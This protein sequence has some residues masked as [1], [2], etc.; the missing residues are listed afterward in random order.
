[1]ENR[2]EAVWAKHRRLSGK[3]EFWPKMLVTWILAS[4]QRQKAWIARQIVYKIMMSLSIN[5]VRFEKESLVW[6][7]RFFVDAN[8]CCD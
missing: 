4:L 2:K 6:I 8:F 7:L 1:V 5:N 3:R